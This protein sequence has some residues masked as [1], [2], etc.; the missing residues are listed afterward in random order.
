MKIEKFTHRNRRDFKALFA[1]D[2]KGCDHKEESWGY[3]D[4]NFHQNVV[5]QMKCKKCG[6]TSPKKEAQQQPRYP[7]GLQL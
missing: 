6:R 5:P 7:E 3:D 2:N 4:M 1:C